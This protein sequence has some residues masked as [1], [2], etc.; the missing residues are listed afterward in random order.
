LQAAKETQLIISNKASLLKTVDIA[1]P[2]TFTVKMLKL[3]QA[4]LLL[5]G[6]KKPPVYSKASLIQAQRLSSHGFSP[7]KEDTSHFMK[8]PITHDVAISPVLSPWQEPQVFILARKVVDIASLLN[9]DFSQFGSGSVPGYRSKETPSLKPTLSWKKEPPNKT[10]PILLSSFF[11][12]W[13]WEFSESDRARVYGGSR[14]M[15]LWVVSQWLRWIPP[16][17]SL[18]F[19]ACPLIALRFTVAGGSVAERVEEALV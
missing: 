6:V 11:T 16:I 3:R 1:K 18:V 5:D 17:L 10:D 8:D 15:D 14:I 9:L 2:A 7:W 13:M 4:S 19:A 12:L